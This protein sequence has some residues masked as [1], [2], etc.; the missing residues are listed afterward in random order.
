[1]AVLGLSWFQKKN[2][3]GM[4]LRVIIP[5]IASQLLF[6]QNTTP[7]V[8]GDNG[9]YLAGAE[10]RISYFLDRYCG[11]GIKGQQNDLFQAASHLRELA[12]ISYCV[13]NY[14]LD[15]PKS[16]NTE[17]ESN[18]GQNPL[19]TTRLIGWEHNN[20]LLIDKVAASLP[21]SEPLAAPQDSASEP[22]VQN[23]GN[24]PKVSTPDTSSLPGEI[25]KFLPESYSKLPQSPREGTE[26]KEA[27]D[28]Q[29]DKQKDSKSSHPKAASGKLPVPSTTLPSETPN[30][31][32]PKPR[33]PD[34]EV[35]PG[36]VG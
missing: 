19:R 30:A 25:D 24:F 35:K 13:R 3:S 7:F 11:I 6:I 1:M 32:L 9:W 10:N 2:S 16:Q 28:T 12:Q 22:T 4:Q 36:S 20:P 14:N 27:P 18:P 23:A 17:S 29:I 34:Q 5:T 21:G 31:N 15:A 33:K 8:G 26:L